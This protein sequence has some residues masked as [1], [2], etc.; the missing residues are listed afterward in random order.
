LGPD[1][2]TLDSPPNSAHFD[3]K[4]RFKAPPTTVVIPATTHAPPPHIYAPYPGPSVPNYPQY[5]PPPTPDLTQLLLS[6]LLP[7]I[8]QRP[9][10]Q[11]NQPGNPYGTPPQAYLYPPPST[12]TPLVPSPK[13]LPAAI[14]PRKIHLEEFCDRYGIPDADRPKL[15]KLGI[16][17][18]LG[19]KEVERLDRREWQ[20]HAG[21][22][23]LSWSFFVKKHREF[24]ADVK[25]GQWE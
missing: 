3:E 24:I 10:L 25:S 20:E 17:M 5:P 11:P 23:G 16:E 9:A 12:P 7:Q 6:A 22:S 18:W 21:M 13:S 8:L 19:S 2:A 4:V 15:E 1:K 14:M